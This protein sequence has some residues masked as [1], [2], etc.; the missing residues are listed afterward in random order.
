MVNKSK[1]DSSL[2]SRVHQYLVE[3]GVETPMTDR[4]NDSS[5]TTTDDKLRCVENSF[6]EIMETLGM[7]LTDD[8]LQDTPKRVAKM[9]VNELFWG[10]NYDNFPKCTAIENKM[11]YDE[12]VLEKDITSMSA[13]EHHFVT[14]DGKAKVAYIPDKVVL[15]LSKI[16]RVVEFF[17]RR[18]QVQ[19]RLTEQIFHALSYIL[20][21]ENIAV[22][23]E[24][25]HYCVK[26]RGV[27]DYGSSTITSKLGGRFKDVPSLRSEFLSL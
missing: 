8:S 13:C 19:E 27:R 25:V 20:G 16:N 15:G 21:T 26:S 4:A 1:T 3:K 22:V 6:R 11:G 18:P 17:S 14:I 5:H 9:Y 23:V 12:M 2:G 10:L 7:D 24:G